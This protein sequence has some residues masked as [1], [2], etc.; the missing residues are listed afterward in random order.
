[1]QG[2][3]WVCLDSKTTIKDQLE[4][5]KTRDSY[6]A[7]DYTSAYAGKSNNYGAIFKFT[8]IIWQTNSKKVEH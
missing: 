1:M 4:V 6:K 5:K 8:I 3:V 2:I 7:I